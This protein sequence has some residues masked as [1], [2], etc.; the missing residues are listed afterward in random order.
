MKPKTYAI[1]STSPRP[2]NCRELFQSNTDGWCNMRDVQKKL[3]E[4]LDENCKR[5]AEWKKE[6][7]KALYNYLRDFKDSKEKALLNG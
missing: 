7:Y 1:T 5:T 4:I 6:R 3:E 2:L